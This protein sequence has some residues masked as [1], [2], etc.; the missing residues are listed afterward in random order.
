MWP[1]AEMQTPY[2]SGVYIYDLKTIF[3]KVFIV[4]LKGWIKVSLVAPMLSREMYLKY[5]PL[6]N[7][8][9]GNDIY[10]FIR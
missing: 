5:N 10:Y 3:E 6:K 4:V 7:E 8:S 2:L 1:L 9:E